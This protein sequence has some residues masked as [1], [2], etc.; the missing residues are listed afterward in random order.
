MP[1]TEQLMNYENELRLRT[2]A[3]DPAMRISKVTRHKPIISVT[4][5]F[6]VSL[7][8]LSRISGHSVSAVIFECV[9]KQSK[10]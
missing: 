6:F 5:A 8:T 4:L 10:H 3:N 7:S 2:E 9:V 1:L